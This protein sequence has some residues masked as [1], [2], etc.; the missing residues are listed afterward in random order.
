M[1]TDKGSS[2]WNESLKLISYCPLCETRYRPVSAQM[3]GE[4]EET[5]LLYLTCGKCGSSLLALVLV[6]TVGA[7]SVGLITDLSFDDVIRFKTARRVTTNDV[8]AVHELLEREGLSA[9][10]DPVRKR[11]VRNS[12]S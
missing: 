5:H 10:S 4:E 11:P 9:F 2:V 1:A 12:R 6:N 7:S 8:I 3:L